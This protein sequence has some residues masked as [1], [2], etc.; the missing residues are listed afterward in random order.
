VTGGSFEAPHAPGSFHGDYA[1]G[2][3][4]SNF[5]GA[6]GFPEYSYPADTSWP[7]VEQGTSQQFSIQPPGWIEQAS[8]VSSSLHPVLSVLDVMAY[9]YRPIL[10]LGLTFVS[11]SKSCLLAQCVLLMC[12]FESSL[13]SSQALG[14]SSLYSDT[15]YV[16]ERSWTQFPER[17][18]L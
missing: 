14:I 1:Y 7:A 8:P 4:A 9:W 13:L 12:N 18:L 2:T 11:G 6:H 15:G 5:S 16:G 3:Y 17:L 10:A